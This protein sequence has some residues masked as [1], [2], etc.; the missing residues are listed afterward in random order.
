M[1]RFKPRSSAAEVRC[2]FQGRRQARRPFSAS[3]SRA[4]VSI[5]RHPTPMKS[6]RL[7]FAVP[8]LLL[9][10]LSACNSSRSTRIEEHAS[11]FAALDPISKERVRN[12]DVDVGFHRE[13][14]YMSI[15]KPTRVQPLDGKEGA[16]TWVYPNFVVG[17]SS[18]I[19]L[20]VNNPGSRYQD[21]Q[22]SANAPRSGGSLFDTKPSGPRPT[23]DDGS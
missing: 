6:T 11:I 21:R 8:V 3:R 20:A 9:T 5:V 15:G 13:H 22:I 18:A 4:A 19:A 10:T 12:G 16:E 17:S 23:I 1:T 7:A 2:R 14:V